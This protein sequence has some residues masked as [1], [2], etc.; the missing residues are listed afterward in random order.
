MARLDCQGGGNSGSAN[1]G[2]LICPLVPRLSSLFLM[3][4]D[5]HAYNQVYG[6]LHEIPILPIM[7]H[8]LIFLTQP[9]NGI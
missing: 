9:V 3:I 5:T 7:E 1:L 4:F 2:N 8:L 6:R